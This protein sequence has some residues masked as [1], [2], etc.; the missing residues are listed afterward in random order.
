METHRL[1]LKD[2]PV[3]KAREIFH[4]Q[5]NQGS[6][7][8]GG[9]F[10]AS[11]KAAFKAVTQDAPGFPDAAHSFFQ[12]RDRCARRRPED[13]VQ[14]LIGADALI[15]PEVGACDGDAFIQRTLYARYQAGVTRAP[16]AGEFDS[17][18][19]IQPVPVG[20]EAKVEQ[21]HE[22]DEVDGGLILDFRMQVVLGPCVGAVLL[23]LHLTPYCGGCSFGALH[24]QGYVRGIVVDELGVGE[25]MEFGRRRVSVAI[26][27][28]R[29]GQQRQ[30]LEVGGFVIR[31]LGGSIS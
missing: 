22:E 6:Y 15:R 24:I 30:Q 20:P 31:H 28:Q 3:V 14:D 16:F 21:I 19:L 17:E 26:P 29:F 8:A 27:P 9:L 2:M 25:H 18:D 7:R 10:D 4:D 11:E 13:V 23:F 12:Q 5:I 1:V